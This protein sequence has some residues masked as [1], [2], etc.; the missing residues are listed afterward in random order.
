MFMSTCAKCLCQDMP[1]VYVNM[2]QMF[3]SRY[4]KCLCQHVS[5]VCVKIC[6]MFMSTCAKCL[7]QDMPNVYVNM[8]QMSALRYA[9]CMCQHISKLLNVI[10][11]LWIEHEMVLVRVKRPNYQLLAVVLHLVVVRFWIGVRSRWR[12]W[13]APSCQ[14]LSKADSFSYTKK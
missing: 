4:A 8:C 6:Q 2:C 1:N 13:R 5:N 11:V 9:K 14:S 3:V 10:N 7:C 12:T